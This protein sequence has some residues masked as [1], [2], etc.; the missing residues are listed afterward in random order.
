MRGAA[1]TRVVGRGARALLLAV[2]CAVAW[3]ALADAT[4]QSAAPTATRADVLVLGAEPEAIAAAIAAAETGART[5]LATEN[6]RL[7][8]LFVLGAMNVLDVRTS[9]RNYQEGIFARWWARVGGEGAFDPVRAER[10]FEAMLAA[11]GVEVRTGLRALRITASDGVA[12]GVT[13][14]GGKL[15]AA[16]I[17]D[18]HADMRYAHAAGAAA[19]VGWRSFHVDLRMADTL[20]FRMEGIDWSALRRAAEQR[21]R[22]WASVDDRVA[23]GHFGGVPAAYPAQDPDVRL[24]GLNLGRDDAGGV[25]ANAL[26]IHGVDP[27][28]PEARRDARARAEAEAERAVGW[29]AERLPGF[30]DARLAG[31]ADRLYVRET[32][33]L[34]AACVLDAD[35]VLDNVMG[36][37]DL[38]VGGYPLDVQALTRQDDGY[39]FGTPVMYGV[40]ACVAV[41]SEG[42]DALWVV[43]RSAGYDPIAHASARVVPQGMAVAEGVG[44]A[45]ALAGATGRPA[46]ELAGDAA[47][48]GEVRARLRARG[49]YLP[50][51]ASRPPVGPHEHA[52]YGAYRTMLSRGLAVGGFDNAP[53]LDESVPALSHLYL[54]ANVATRFL[55]RRG[56]ARDLVAAYGGVTGPAQARDVA[57][58]QRAAACRLPAATCPGGASP[59][60]LAAAGAWPDGVPQEG[61]LTRGEVY[62]LGEALL[63]A[64]RGR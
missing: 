47:F 4:A 54:V 64:A 36:P 19:S 59:A 27:F 23:W 25:W 32:R 10:A 26:L 35:H 39:V 15:R 49:A 13:W 58:V 12:R 57:H 53:R 56:L 18:G 5:V 1:P 61:P 41:P 50:A 21:G 6:D 7:G 43:G 40:P 16:Q 28:D 11:A 46:A 22:S 20:M 63:H 45:A 30:E 38:A 48:V 51:P 31:V 3:G 34:E 42:P 8:G 14:R 9:P 24:R 33:H 52:H 2:V 62:A 60:D 55:D 44:V 29:L 17:V 37:L